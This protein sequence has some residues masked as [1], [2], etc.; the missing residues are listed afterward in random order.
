MS[1][2]FNYETISVDR[3]DSDHICR[4]YQY[5]KSVIYEERLQMYENT[6]LTE[7]LL[8]LERNNNSGKVDHS[9]SGINSK[10]AA[11]AL[12]G[13]VFNASKHADEFAFDY[14]ETLDTIKE[15]SSENKPAFFVTIF[16]EY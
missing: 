15:V 3:V 6:L 12:C 5:L 16:E 1:R 2:G 4:P 14:G 13:A 11:D 7:E 10:D 8:G 9:P